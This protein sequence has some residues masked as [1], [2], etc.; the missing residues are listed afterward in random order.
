MDNVNMVYFLYGI[1]FFTLGVYSPGH[2]G[3]VHV[4]FLYR[5]TLIIKIKIIVNIY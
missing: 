1:Y 4:I 5:I 2:M 3:L